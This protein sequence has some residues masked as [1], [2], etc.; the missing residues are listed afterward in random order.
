MRISLRIYT[1]DAREVSGD[2]VLRCLKLV[3][4]DAAE[5]SRTMGPANYFQINKQYLA[6]G[7][8][9]SPSRD[10]SGLKATDP[11]RISRL[12]R[13]SCFLSVDFGSSTSS[14]FA[15]L[16]AALD[17][18]LPDTSGFFMSTIGFRFGPEDIVDVFENDHGEDD[19]KLIATSYFSFFLTCDDFLDH[20]AVLRKAVDGVPELR[21][22]RLELEDI[23][24]PLTVLALM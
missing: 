23:F 12:F 15:A 1:A 22:L 18:Y 24:G 5:V 2:S 10:I 14:R 20:P 4:F 19:V 13:P 17:K 21:R 9:E 7:S 11:L 16:V 3:D 8:A 6:T